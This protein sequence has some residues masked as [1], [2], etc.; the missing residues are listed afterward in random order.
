MTQ[1][2]LAEARLDNLVLVVYRGL[3]VGGATDALEGAAGTDRI[4]WFTDKPDT[5]VLIATLIDDVEDM[6]ALLYQSCLLKVTATV[7]RPA[8]R[9]DA[10]G[11]GLPDSN[12]AHNATGSAGS[13][14][15][16]VR[17]R[18]TW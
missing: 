17:V 18:F 6:A 4:V 5:A 7:R 1:A 14:Q 10:C 15:L 8:R 2:Q 16:S 3:A 12:V 13:G 9:N 11:A